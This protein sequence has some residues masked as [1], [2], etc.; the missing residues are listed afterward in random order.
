MVKDRERTTGAGR[1]TVG[2][3]S[4][5]GGPS[6][7]KV[8]REQVAMTVEACSATVVLLSERLSSPYNATSWCA[9]AST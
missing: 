8:G 2:G 7:A 5:V 9:C 4:G 3:E 1:K 6:V